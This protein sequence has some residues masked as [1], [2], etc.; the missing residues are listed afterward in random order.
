MQYINIVPSMIIFIIVIIVKW[1]M[2]IH[3]FWQH[4]IQ[5]LHIDIV[6]RLQD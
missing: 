6:L 4:P 1:K 5:Q 2:G 3:E